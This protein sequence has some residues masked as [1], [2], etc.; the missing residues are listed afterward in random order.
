MALPIAARRTPR[1]LDVKA[2]SLNAGCPKRL[3]VAMPTPSPL[4]SSA[5]L[6]R[7]TMR[8]RS[9]AGVP[10]GTRSSSCRLIP[11]APSSASLPTLSTGS[12]GARVGPPNGSRP[13]LPTVQSPNV[14]RCSGRGSSASPRAVSTINDIRFSSLVS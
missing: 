7:L 5:A 11:H 10:H 2:P 8:S 9:A 13:G 3:V 12:S 1:S 14:N 4:A 6:K